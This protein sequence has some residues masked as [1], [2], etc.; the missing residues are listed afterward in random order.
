MS[1]NPDN[2]AK[3]VEETV[4]KVGNPPI[5]QWD[6]E[7]SGDMDLRISRDGQWIF[8]GEPLARE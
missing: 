7:L 6:P 4:K 5:D 8:K 1:M 2:L 3:Q